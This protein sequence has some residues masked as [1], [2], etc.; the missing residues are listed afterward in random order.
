MNLNTVDVIA[1][2]RWKTDHIRPK[3]A[4]G[5]NRSNPWTRERHHGDG[6]ECNA[7]ENL[8]NACHRC[9]TLKRNFDP[10][11]KTRS[12]DRE[13]LVAAAKD[14]I[15]AKRQDQNA[16]INQLIEITERVSRPEGHEV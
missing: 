13:A 16:R 7:A 2:G 11:K 6:C 10:T 14:Y 3:V 12:R 4:F 8:A 1:E 9:N 15:D 5:H